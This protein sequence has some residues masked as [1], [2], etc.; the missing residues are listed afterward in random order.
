DVAGQFSNGSVAFTQVV[1][2]AALRPGGYYEVAKWFCYDMTNR[3]T[4]GV[5]VDPKVFSKGEWTS[6]RTIG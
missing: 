3:H 6:K 5:G 4:L 2:K 1:T